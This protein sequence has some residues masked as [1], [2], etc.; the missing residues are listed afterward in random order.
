M[1]LTRDRGIKMETSPKFPSDCVLERELDML[2]NALYG[3]T[4]EDIKIVESTA[5]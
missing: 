5:K 2:V 4:P 1:S 3:L